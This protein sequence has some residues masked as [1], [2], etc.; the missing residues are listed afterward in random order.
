M[1]LSV[2]EP[3]FVAEEYGEQFRA[4]GIDAWKYPYTAARKD[5]H[6]ILCLHGFNHRSCTSF[7]IAELGLCPQR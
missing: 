5:R 6:I 1:L 7:E 3:Q 4:A 2:V